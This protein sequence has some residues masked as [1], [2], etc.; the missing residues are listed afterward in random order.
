MFRAALESHNNDFVLLGIDYRDIT[1]DARKFADDKHATW[2][3]LKDP[4]NDVALGLRRARGAPD[5]LHR[6]RRQ[7]LAALL[8]AGPRVTSSSRS[9]R[10]SPSR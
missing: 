6:A 2:P 10:R 8:R 5:L 3:I 7:D 1:S 9:W 4:G